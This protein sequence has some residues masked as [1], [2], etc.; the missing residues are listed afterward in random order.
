MLGI[1]FVVEG[2]NELSFAWGFRKKHRLLGQ[3][4]PCNRGFNNQN[5]TPEKSIEHQGHHSY[6]THSKNSMGVEEFRIYR[7][8]SC[9]ASLQQTSL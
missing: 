8:P 9:S 5:P 3:V 6:E 2:N 4:S 1:T 7:L